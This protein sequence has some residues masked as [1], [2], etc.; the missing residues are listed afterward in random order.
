MANEAKGTDLSQSSPV[1]TTPNG[2]NNDTATNATDFSPATSRPSPKLLCGLCSGIVQTVIFNPF[3]RAL[4]LAVRDHT[5][6]LSKRNFLTP[7][8]GLSQ[9][10]LVRA[11]S[12][13]LYFPL[14]HSF[15][16]LLGREQSRY[17]F[18]SGSAA[19]VLSSAILNPLTAL[20]YQ[21]WCVTELF[22][23]LAFDEYDQLLIVFLLL[24]S[25]LLFLL[26]LWTMYVCLMSC[27]MAIHSR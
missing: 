18:L 21:T 8:Q 17:H 24:I 20:K 23:A 12:A 13:G 7:F 10:I 22:C 26:C 19:G 6:F 25:F 1:T 16:D 27:H 9:A 2:D 15:L 4:F 5:P 11:L 14:E 3:D